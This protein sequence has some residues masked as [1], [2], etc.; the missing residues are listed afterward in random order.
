VPSGRT[1]RRAVPKPGALAR[2]RPTCYAGTVEPDEAP[3]PAA[4]SSRR[5]PR[6]PYLALAVVAVALLA[7]LIWFLT[8]GGLRRADLDLL[9]SDAALVLVVDVGDVYDG[10]LGE[11]VRDA[12]GDLERDMR[13]AVGFVPADVSHVL[14]GMDAD[15]KTPLVVIVMKRSLDE[16]AVLRTAKALEL[17]STPQDVGGR[18]LYRG[19]VREASKTLGWA[20]DNALV[21]G[22]R[23]DVEAALRRR[24]SRCRIADLLLDHG[25]LD[26]SAAVAFDF[27]G[28][29]HGMGLGHSLD[30]VLPSFRRHCGAFVARLDVSRGLGAEVKLLSR[31]GREVARYSFDLDRALLED[32]LSDLGNL[33]PKGPGRDDDWPPLPKDGR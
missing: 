24:G 14:V 30:E 22:S 29:L 23:E 28:A 12:W 31:E 2:R 6:R 17:G 25:G 7:V 15:M 5:A 3:A 16:E 18:P 27:T 21:V 13:E 8:R 1:F 19:T 10:W 32:L 9:P 33:L 20:S 11:K 26:A 4:S